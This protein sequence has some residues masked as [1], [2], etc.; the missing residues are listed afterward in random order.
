MKTIIGCSIIGF[1]AFF[2]M[3][4]IS[5]FL[6]EYFEA[7]NGDSA[8]DAGIKI[9]PFMGTF[10]VSATLCGVVIKKTGRYWHMMVAFPAFMSIG[11]GLLYTLDQNTPYAKIAGFQVIFALGIGP[12]FQNVCKS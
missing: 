2:G 5:Y 1:C 6:T 7:V 4:I 8:T 9:L 10:I 12:V 3:F 11:S